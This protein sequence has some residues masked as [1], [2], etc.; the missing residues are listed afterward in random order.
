MPSEKPCKRDDILQKSPVILRRLLKQ[1]LLIANIY[2][3]KQMLLIANIY[4]EKNDVAD[5]SHRC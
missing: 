4:E 5:S 1:M 2:E 3:L